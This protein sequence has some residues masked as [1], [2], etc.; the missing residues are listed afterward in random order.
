MKSKK[1]YEFKLGE[2]VVYPKHGVGEII[3]KESMEISSIKTE[4]Y[5]VK[6]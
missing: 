3:K 1:N 2:I 6:M 4:F 5:V